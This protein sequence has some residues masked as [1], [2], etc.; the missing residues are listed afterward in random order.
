MR[1]NRSVR[2]LCADF[3]GFLAYSTV[4][5]LLWHAWTTICHVEN[6]IPKMW[7]NPATTNEQIDEVLDKCRQN[8]PFY[9]DLVSQFEDPTGKNRLPVCLLM[10][11]T[12]ILVTKTK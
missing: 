8:D 6:Q 10:D 3:G 11:S 9:Q 2:D 7:C 5:E 12:K 1:K 4:R